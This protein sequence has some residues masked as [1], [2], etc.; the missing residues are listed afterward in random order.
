MRN[1]SATEL[2]VVRHGETVWN[3]EGR[4]QGH[5]DSPLSPLGLRQAQAIANRLA[6]ERF[7]AIYS[8]DLGRAWAT[9]ER[10]TACHDLEIHTDPRLRERHLGIFQIGNT[11]NFYLSHCLV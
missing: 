4:Q 6:S 11:A 10:I 2:T 9:A 3:N 8:S 1:S 7:N 5:L